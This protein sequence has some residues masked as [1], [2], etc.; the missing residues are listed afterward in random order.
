MKFTRKCS[1][2]SSISFQKT[3]ARQFCQKNFAIHQNFR[4]L[5]A[6]FSFL[7]CGLAYAILLSISLFT[8]KHTVRTSAC[9]LPTHVW[10]RKGKEKNSNII[11]CKFKFNETLNTNLISRCWPALVDFAF[12]FWN[13]A[14]FKVIWSKTSLDQPT[15]GSVCAQ[16][17]LFSKQKLFNRCLSGNDDEFDDGKVTEWRRAERR[18]RCAVALEILNWNYEFRFFDLIGQQSR[19]QTQIFC[20]AASKSLGFSDC[21]ILFVSFE[22]NTI[23][24][25]HRFWREITFFVIEFPEFDFSSSNFFPSSTGRRRRRQ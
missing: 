3:F 2:F 19:R 1:S 16:D 14:Y 20:C 4:I 5:S 12:N 21:E 22:C 6:I 13:Q 9:D 11:F 24:P 25:F 10:I 8:H 7:S 23:S 17:N 18:G 15:W